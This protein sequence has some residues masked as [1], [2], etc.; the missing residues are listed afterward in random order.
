MKKDKKKTTAP[1]EPAKPDLAKIAADFKTLD[2]QDPIC[3][4]RGDG[5]D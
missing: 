5:R 1:T 2:E 4:H 3:A